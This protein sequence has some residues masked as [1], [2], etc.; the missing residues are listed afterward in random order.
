VVE[1]DGGALGS[2]CVAIFMFLFAGGP[3]LDCVEAADVDDNGA[4]ELTDAIALIGYLF[5]GDP[6][7]GLP[8]PGCGAD[9]TPDDLGCSTY[10][11][12]LKSG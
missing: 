2:E 1:N 4:L 8:F 3:S 9:P 12:C 6:A 11:A 10:G 7:P 5:L